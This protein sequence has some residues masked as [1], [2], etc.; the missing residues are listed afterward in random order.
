MEVRVSIEDV[1]LRVRIF[2]GRGPAV[3]GDEA[4]TATLHVF[5]PDAGAHEADLTFEFEQKE[6]AVQLFS[7]IARAIAEIDMTGP[8]GFEDDDDEIPLVREGT[9][10]RHRA[11][12]VAV[13][14]AG[15]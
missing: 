7:A 15:A 12:L 8:H 5:E 14:G 9:L 10:D 3:L 6:H 4:V 11:E 13:E 2:A 1:G